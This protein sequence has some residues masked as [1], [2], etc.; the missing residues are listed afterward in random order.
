MNVW[1][2]IAL[3]E[4]TKSDLPLVLSWRNQEYIR[5]MMYNSE[6]ISMDRHIAWFNKIQKSKTSKTL[7]FYFSGE[8]YGIVNIHQINFLKGTC[9]WGLYI[10]VEEAPRGLGT[11]L[12]YLAIE[13]VFNSLRLRKL[14][15]EVLDFNHKSYNFHKKMGFEQEGVLKE[16]IAKEGKY[17][18]IILF[19]LSLSKWVEQSSLIKR[20]ITIQFKNNL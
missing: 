17:V 7:I 4:M 2:K 1:S 11:I 6:I 8:P 13:Y 5:K 14:H 3:R 18:D 15:A 9:E 16:H 10:G 19:G 20:Q 12:G